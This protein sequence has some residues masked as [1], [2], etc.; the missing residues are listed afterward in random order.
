[1]ILLHQ[2]QSF[3]LFVEARYVYSSANWLTNHPFLPFCVSIKVPCVC[4][5]VIL[6]STKVI[7]LSSHCKQEICVHTSVGEWRPW[8]RR[9]GRT[10]SGSYRDPLCYENGPKGASCLPS[11]CISGWAHQK[12]SLPSCL[13]HVC[14]SWSE[15]SLSFCLP[16]VCVSWSEKSFSQ[17]CELKCRMIAKGRLIV[18]VLRPFLRQV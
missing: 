10:S 9:S 18:S 2:E 3:S 7:D 6:L 5:L 12:K 11:F 8:L 16:P 14:V 13:L 17:L 15:K 1:M 4:K